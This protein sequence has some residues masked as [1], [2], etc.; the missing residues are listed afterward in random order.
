MQN[1]DLSHLLCSDTLPRGVWGGEHQCYATMGERCC[2]LHGRE[3]EEGGDEREG[4]LRKHSSTSSM[5]W[6]V[7]FV[8]AR[9][10]VVEFLRVKLGFSVYQERVCR[11]TSTS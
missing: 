3:L 9:G 6:L 4:E 10:G 1:H 5:R 2:A 11:Y 7:V 8:R